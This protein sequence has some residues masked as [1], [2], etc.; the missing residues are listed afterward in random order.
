MTD[1]LHGVE[2]VEVAQGARPVVPSE[3]TFI[4]IL[5]TALDGPSGEPR[6]T[7]GP[8]EAAALWGAEGSIPEAIAAIHSQG[9]APAIAA[10]NAL[11]PAAHV[12]AVADEPI[13]WGGVGETIRLAHS[14]VS[15]VSL[16]ESDGTAIDA[17]DFELDAAAGTLKVVSVDNVS[18]GDKSKASYSYLDISKVTAADVAAAAPKLCEA[19]TA[20][21]ETPSVLI[22]PGWTEKVTRDGSRVIDSA[23]VA[24]ALAAVADSCRGIV[25]ADGPGTTRADALAYRA[26]QGSRR[27]YVVDP[28]VKVL[29]AGGGTAEAPASGYVAGLIAR[30]DAEAGWWASPSN[31]ELRGIAGTSRFVSFGLGDPDA[32][33]NI[34]NA[35]EVA[36]LVR[37][38]GWRLWGNRT[39]SAD[40]KWQFLSVVRTRRPHQRGHPARAPVGRRSQHHPQLRLRRGRVGQRLPALAGLRRGH[41]GRALL[42]RRGP[43]RARLAGRRQAVPGLRVHR[44][45]TR[46]SASPSAPRW[47]TT[48]RRP[49]SRETTSWRS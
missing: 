26:T 31:R 27:M 44:R 22:A 14:R 47:S 29:A 16:K 34:L 37:A 5:G 42:G 6:T 36:T 48:T 15:G 12:S 4:G 28:K 41:P 38:T 23:P 13:E 18:A 8:V 39:C 43:Q 17:A 25:V 35:A 7:L 2:V 49:S 21:G 1:Y 32:E 19:A 24:S 11:D 33:A 20:S 46:P 3:T 30:T 40:P 45:P 9:R 10:V